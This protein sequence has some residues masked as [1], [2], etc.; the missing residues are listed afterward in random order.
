[1]VEEQIEGT[2]SQED[3][4]A[5]V[6]GL[7]DDEMQALHLLITLVASF[8]VQIG[9][10]RESLLENIERGFEVNQSVGGIQ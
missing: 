7:P 8:A 9:M 6:D 2:W 4:D 1:M 3:L 10:T 5:V